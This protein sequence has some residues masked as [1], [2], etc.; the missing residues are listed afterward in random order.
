MEKFGRTKCAVLAAFT[1]ISINSFT[2]PAF[3]QDLVP[4]KLYWSNGV[5]DNFVTAT[6]QGE[7][8]AI[9]SGYK[10]IRTEACVFRSQKAG[11]VPLNL[12]WSGAR[13]EK[14][15]FTTATTQGKSDAIGSGYSF[16]R[17][18]G[19]VYSTQQPG[20]IPLKLYWSGHRTDRKDN[21]TTGTKEGTS[22]ALGSDYV[23]VRV[24]GY[25]YPA[26][27]CQ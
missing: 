13:A 9:G 8:D 19:Y 27:K 16:V 1:T 24:E 6:P 10:Y 14:D 25:A 7:S 5:R 15:N 3:A 26:T 18:E 23:F 17:T 12:Y 21:F 2:V 22:D 11:L 20:T 4:L